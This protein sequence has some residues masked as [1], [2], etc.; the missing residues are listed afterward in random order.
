MTDDISATKH[1]RQAIATVCEGFTLPDA[2]R[3]VLET[4]LWNPPTES[5]TTPAEVDGAVKALQSVAGHYE[6]GS[7]AKSTLLT[8]SVLVDTLARQLAEARALAYVMPDDPEHGLLTWKERTYEE[9]A[10]AEHAESQLAEVWARLETWLG[11]YADAIPA[12]AYHELCT[13]QKLTKES[14]A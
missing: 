10:R 9:S 7:C 13:I 1:Y 12:P 11:T 3:K 2:A 14:T 5:A 8:A 4:A 6:E